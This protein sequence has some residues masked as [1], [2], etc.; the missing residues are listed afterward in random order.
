[1]FKKLGSVARRRFRLSS[2]ELRIALAFSVLFGVGAL[3]F[4][5]SN[6]KMI[7]QSYNYQG[8]MIEQKR[9]LNINKRLKLERESLRSL[10]RVRTIA[11]NQLGFV[12]P[13]H[14]QTVTVFLK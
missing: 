1:M 9:L 11:V 14:S 13:D 10:S 2:K 6:V 5:W 8:Q 7:Q 12:E 4:V 3:A